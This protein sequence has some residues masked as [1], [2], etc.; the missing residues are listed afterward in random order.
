[1]MKLQIQF[2]RETH[3]VVL[4]HA[5]TITAVVG[6]MMSY[7]R[8]CDAAVERKKT[9]LLRVRKHESR[10]N[11]VP[12]TADSKVLVGNYFIVANKHGACRIP[13]GA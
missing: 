5:A 13:T 4:G 8:E 1:M 9:S 7:G 10:P 6:G 12:T 2:I 3:A 11:I